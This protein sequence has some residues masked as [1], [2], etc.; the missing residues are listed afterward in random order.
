MTYSERLALFAFAFS[1]LPL[2]PLVYN[3]VYA[4]YLLVGWLLVA[5]FVLHQALCLAAL[6][7][8]RI[9][10]AYAALLVLILGHAV[11]AFG[12]GGVDRWPKELLLEVLAVVA[13]WICVTLRFRRSP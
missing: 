9:S 8:R 3:P 11:E 5:S 13:T 4:I 6:V 1:F 2:T 7:K 12:F 10:L